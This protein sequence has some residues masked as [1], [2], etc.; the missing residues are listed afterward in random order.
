MWVALGRGARLSYATSR[1]FRKST[2]LRSYRFLVAEDGHETERGRALEGR[3]DRAEVHVQIRVAVHHPEEVA[4]E[5]L[6][7]LQGAA[8]AQEA[9]PSREYS[10][11]R[12]KPRPSPTNASIC[13]PR[14]PVHTTTRRTPFRRNSASWWAMNGWPATSKSAFGTRSETDRRRVPR[15]P[16]RRASGT[17][18]QRRRDRASLAA[19]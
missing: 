8:R 12:P 1:P 3:Q 16:A 10:T 5:G 7:L 14:C 9:P 4:Q 17:S 18:V 13:S 2:L 19:H 11:A 15:P 6:G